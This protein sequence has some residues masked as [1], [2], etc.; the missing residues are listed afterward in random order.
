MGEAS[1]DAALVCFSE[2][3]AQRSQLVFQEMLLGTACGG[4]SLV[5]L[6]NGFDHHTAINY[7][8]HAVRSVTPPLNPLKNLFP[9][10]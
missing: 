3:C 6:T 4:V 5:Q 1:D 10:R 2:H 9:Y 7:T 8:E